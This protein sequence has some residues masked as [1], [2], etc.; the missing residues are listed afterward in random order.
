MG[1]FRA[2]GSDDTV[3]SCAVPC[4]HGSYRKLLWVNCCG[5]NG[6]LIFF[7]WAHYDAWTNWVAFGW[8]K[9]FQVAF[10]PY[11][12]FLTGSGNMP[13]GLSYNLG[14]DQWEQIKWPLTWMGIQSQVCIWCEQSLAA[15]HSLRKEKKKNRWYQN[16]IFHFIP[17]TR[18][19]WKDKLYWQKREKNLITRSDYKCEHGLIYTNLPWVELVL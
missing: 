8:P 15:Y 16:P 11:L 6:C 5:F 1:I 10:S 4:L 12:M 19:D 2:P 13:F 14:G 17:N 18:Q 9:K 7:F 3:L